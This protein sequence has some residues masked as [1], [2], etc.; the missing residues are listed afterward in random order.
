MG[1]KHYNSEILFRRWQQLKPSKFQVLEELKNQ[2]LSHEETLFVWEDYY[3]YRLER[4]NTLGWA[5]MGAGGFLGLVSC[6]LTILD[7]IPAI[8]GFLMYGLTG[9]AVSIAFYGCY[10]VMEKPTDE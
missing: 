6:V 3:R 10:L 1:P 8:R 2:G 9:M 4:R 7:S 5:L